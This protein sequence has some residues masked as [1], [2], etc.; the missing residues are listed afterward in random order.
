MVVLQILHPR[1][2]SKDICAYY[3]TISWISESLGRLRTNLRTLS[4]HGPRIKEENENLYGI[5]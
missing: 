2:Q 3:A 5:L 1:Q 4:E